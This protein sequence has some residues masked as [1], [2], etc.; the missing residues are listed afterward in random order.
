MIRP[1]APAFALLVL[2]LA[3]SGV[4][5]A[6]PR[7]PSHEPVVRA[8]LELVA[9]DGCGTQA[10]LHER[11]R[12]RS[13]RVR[14]VEPGPAVRRARAELR[15][16]AGGALRATLVWWSDDGRQLVRELTAP[17]CADALDALALVLAVTLDPDAELGELPGEAKVSPAPDG[18][19]DS[20][21]DRRAAQPEQASAPRASQARPANRRETRAGQSDSAPGASSGFRLSVLAGVTAGVRSGAAPGVLPGFGGFVGVELDPALVGSALARLSLN[22]HSRGGF[23]A[24]GGTAMFELDTLRLD[25]CPISFGPAWLAIYGCVAGELGV[26]AA[27]GSQTLD[28]AAR[29]RPWRA[30]AAGALAAVRPLPLVELQ[31]SG[32]IEHALVRDSFEFNPRI[33]HEVSAIGG[34]FELALALSI[35]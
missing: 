18:A 7:Q 17:N 16:G 31:L 28:A 10:E 12:R 26:L 4:V 14:F 9:P 30:L 8:H 27:Q 23:D 6:Q 24:E 21:V 19:P 20:T 32:A 3:L 2:A 29:E 33:F 35:P 25:L 34:R 13:A 5:S 15:A 11:V 1:F 22:R